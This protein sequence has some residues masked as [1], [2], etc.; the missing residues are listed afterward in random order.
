MAASGA[1]S[2]IVLGLH[3][4]GG[5]SRFLK[6]AARVLSAQRDIA[7]RLQTMIGVCPQTVLAIDAFAP[8]IENFRDRRDFAAWLGLVPCQFISGG[9]HSSYST[10]GSV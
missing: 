3:E 1:A 6:C 5:F 2:L 8:P 7:R 10:E 4:A 9:N